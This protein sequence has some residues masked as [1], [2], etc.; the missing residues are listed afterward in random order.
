MSV[1]FEKILL[2]YN[3]PIY[4]TADV[5]HTFVYR[6]GLLDMDFSFAAA[7]GLFNSAI[8]FLLFHM[9][10][11]CRKVTGVEPMVKARCKHHGLQ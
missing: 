3:P 7:V 1:G 2:M 9:N 11:I 8:D 5:I 6:Q 4:E 10:R